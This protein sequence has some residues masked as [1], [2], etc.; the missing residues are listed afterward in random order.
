MK[1][2]MDKKEKKKLPKAAKIILTIVIIAVVIFGVIGAVSVNAAKNKAPEVSYDKVKKTDV[3]QTLSATGS[4]ISNETTYENGQGVISQYPVKSVDVSLGDEVHAGDTLFTLDMSALESDISTQEQLLAAQKKADANTVAGAQDSLNSA[5][6]TSSLTNSDAARSVTSATEDLQKA[7]ADEVKAEADLA[8]LQKKESDAKTAMDNL[9]GP[10]N[11]AKSDMASKQSA[12]YKAQSDAAAK[13][14]GAQAGGADVAFDFATSTA[15]IAYQQA[16]ANYQSVAAEYNTA[17]SDYNAAKAARETGETALDTA[18]QAL[19]QAQRA[20]DTANSTSQQTAVQNSS[21][22]S[23]QQNALNGAKLSSE[24]ST[25]QTNAQI[26]NDKK[27]LE[28]GIVTAEKDGTVTAVNVKPGMIYAGDSAVV[29]DDMTGFKA[30][31]NVDEAD[32]SKITVGQK[33]EIKTDATEDDVLKGTVTFVSP[34]STAMAQQGASTSSDTAAATT[35]RASYRVD[36]TLDHKDDR[37]RLG[38]TAKIN[39]IIA[40]S[41]DT[42]AVPD[43][44]IVTDKDGNSFVTAVI[45]GRETKVPVETGVKNDYLTEVKSDK[46]KEKM[47][48]VQVSDSSDSADEINNET[49]AVDA[50]Y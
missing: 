34:V 15:Q 29:I 10:Y 1:K 46:L 41:D 19:T 20:L 2:V 8:D 48:I 35:S 22:V 28:K 23:A 24:S 47:K 12:Y 43:E 6:T 7:Q 9:Y 31:L 3:K 37:L 11:S 16:D 21:T 25:I 32:I 38:M 30:S 40:E 42:L 17:V 26:A 49:D 39:I 18:K 36:I 5:Q 4:I 27:N 13:G 14:S 33:A 50:M 45:D 44:D